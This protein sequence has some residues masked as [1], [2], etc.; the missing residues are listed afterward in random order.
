MSSM[1]NLLSIVICSAI[2]LAIYHAAI[3]PLVLILAGSFH[4]SKGGQD[5]TE[6]IRP[7]A[8]HVE[9]P[10]VTVCVVAH[11]AQGH[12]E[13]CLRAIL[14]AEY[15][16][17]RL[18]VVVVSDASTDGT[19]ELVEALEDPRVSLIRMPVRRGK[20]Y[21]ENRVAPTLEGD[22]IV[23]TDATVQLE[24]RAI[25]ALVEAFTD[26][27]VGAA[28][29]VDILASSN[30]DPEYKY[31]GFEM[32]I[33]R[34]ETEAG[35]IVGNSGS[36]YAVRR[37]IH[38]LTV[39]DHLSRDLAS[40]FLTHQAGYRSVLVPQAR[41]LISPTASVRAE[42]Y[43]KLRTSRRGIE[44]LWHFKHLLNPFRHG[45]FSFKIW[46]HKVVRWLL[47][48]LVLAMGPGSVLLA[49][50]SAPLLAWLIGMSWSAL[51]LFWIL[52]IAVGESFRPQGGVLTTAYLG[53]GML[54][55]T[56]AWGK[57]VLAQG[58]G[59]WDPTPRPPLAGADP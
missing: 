38:A 31:V 6:A 26:Q 36:I 8:S 14:E 47:P 24:R 12:I 58:D 48:P 2:F 56:V 45:I 40:A 21:A 49:S 50:G 51:L 46:S 41:C 33:R 42:Y 29:G 15:P 9:P 19:D 44:T 54:A 43:R 23:N 10:L 35:G 5:T 32:W 34:L 57:V 11:N 55:G 39:P 1:I 4:D 52:T 53:A 22:I 37:F 7:G 13:G 16:R 25:S 28:S 27:R 59:S 20:T 30:D 17:D 3:Y 18:A